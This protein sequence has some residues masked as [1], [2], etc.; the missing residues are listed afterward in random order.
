MLAIG[1]PETIDIHKLDFGFVLF[2]FVQVFT[3]ATTPGGAMRFSTT[4]PS[5]L[6]RVPSSPGA[7]SAR[8]GSD[9]RNRDVFGRPTDW[10]S[11]TPP[12]PTGSPR[13]PRTPRSEDEDGRRDERNERR[14]RR[15]QEREGRDAGPTEPVGLNFR[16]QACERTLRDH[17]NELAAQLLMMQ[18]IVDAVKQDAI[19]KKKTEER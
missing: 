18:Q 5:S 15:N 11:I 19:D 9:E 7:S 17:N 14:E 3:M 1:P 13:S 6:P 16:L 10:S 2:Q 4:R 8:H 12:H